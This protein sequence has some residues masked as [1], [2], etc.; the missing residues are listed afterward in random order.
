MWMPCTEVASHP[1]K[2]DTKP[3]LNVPVSGC[4]S[5]FLHLQIPQIYSG[6]LE[7]AADADC[8]TD[9]LQGE[10]I[11]KCKALPHTNM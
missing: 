2:C 3:V 11:A 9:C 10:R 4:I 1:P 8:P 7:S 5:V 6:S